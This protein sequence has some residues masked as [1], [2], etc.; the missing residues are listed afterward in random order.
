MDMHSHMACAKD[1]C[2][3]ELDNGVVMPL[4]STKQYKP[5]DRIHFVNGPFKGDHAVVNVWKS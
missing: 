3:I 4:V 1:A 2:T 5:G